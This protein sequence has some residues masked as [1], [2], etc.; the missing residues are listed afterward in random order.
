MSLAV[1]HNAVLDEWPSG[2]A[3]RLSLVWTGGEDNFGGDDFFVQ[4][5]DF[6]NKTLKVL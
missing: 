2:I 5:T 4:L 3:P 6:K 1:F